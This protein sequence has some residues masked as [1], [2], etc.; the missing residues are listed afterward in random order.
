MVAKGQES[1]RE[2]RMT[3]RKKKKKERDYGAMVEGPVVE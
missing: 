3:S 2:S 1:R